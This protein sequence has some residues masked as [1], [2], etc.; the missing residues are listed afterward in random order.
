MDPGLEIVA[1]HPDRIASDFHPSKV[2]VIHH[3]LI[4]VP[5]AEPVKVDIGKHSST[6]LACQHLVLWSAARSCSVGRVLPFTMF[7]VQS[8][9]C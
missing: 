9:S 1:D 4:A 8:Q 6:C 5:R 3:V 2:P 7:N